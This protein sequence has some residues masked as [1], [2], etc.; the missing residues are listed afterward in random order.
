M[1]PISPWRCSALVRKKRDVADDRPVVDDGEADP[2]AAEGEARVADA[3]REPRAALLLGR[4]GVVEPAHD[5]LARAQ[6]VQR[7]ELARLVT[8]QQQALGLDPERLGM[9]VERELVLLQRRG[10]TRAAA[11]RPCARS[12]GPR[13]AARRPARRV[14]DRQLEPLEAAVARPAD[15]RLGERAARARARAR[16]ARPTSPTAPA[17]RRRGTR[18]PC[19][20]SRRRRRRPRRGR[21]RACPSPRPGAPRRPRRWRRRRRARRAARRAAARAGARP[22]P[23]RSAGR[24]RPRA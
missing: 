21:R 5:V 10:R 7:G 20:P 11:T 16:R 1:K 24:P 14:A 19:P 2:V 4:R 23:P 15:R 22:P 18:R 8:P 17:P 3:P 9:Q 12:R 6:P 13:R